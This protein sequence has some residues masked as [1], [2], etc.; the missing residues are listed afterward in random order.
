MF[1]S[2]KKNRDAAMGLLFIAIAI[3]AYAASFTIREMVDI[4]IGPRFVPR[5][6]TVVLAALSGVL[7]VQSV[8]VRR[9][10]A[11]KVGSAV[12]AEAAAVASKTEEEAAGR[13]VVNQRAVFWTIVLLV[14]Y[15]SL[16]G[17]LGFVL[18]T[19]VYLFLQFLILTP[20]EKRSWW[21]AALI[22]VVVAVS[23]NYIFVRWFRLMLPTGMLW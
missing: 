15:V 19:T 7:I 14:L 10:L 12:A 16:L 20:K 2:L 5:L 21:L 11:A 9:K 6:T 22:A 18:T 23:V 4:R 1:D 17:M 3:G 8:L 13:E